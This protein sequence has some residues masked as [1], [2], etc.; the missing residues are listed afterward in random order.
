MTN[1]KNKV[2][3][4]L[5]EG[6]TSFFKKLRVNIIRAGGSE[7]ALDLS[8]ADAMELITKYFKLDNDTYIKMVEEIAKNV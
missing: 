1:K 3:V 6:A 5:G 7:N 2:S 4:K 8:Y